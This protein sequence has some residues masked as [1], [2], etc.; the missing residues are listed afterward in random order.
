MLTGG[1]N[2]SKINKLTGRFIRDSR[3]SPGKILLV[4]SEND[5]FLHFLRNIGKSKL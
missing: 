3:M 2:M 5:I 4:E 1:E